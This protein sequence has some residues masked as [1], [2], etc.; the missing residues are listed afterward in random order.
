MGLTAYM[1]SSDP[2]RVST[3]TSRD[4]NKKMRKKL[5][6]PGTKLDIHVYERMYVLDCLEHIGGV[7]VPAEIKRGGGPGIWI[8]YGIGK[9]CP[10]CWRMLVAPDG[11]KEPPVDPVKPVE[12]KPV[13]LRETKKKAV[14]T[15]SG[16]MDGDGPTFNIPVVA[17]WASTHG[18]FDIYQVMDQFQV[19]RTKAY[20]L[21]KLMV[22]SRRLAVTVRRGQGQ[23]STFELIK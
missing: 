23:R 12:E 2:N 18:E 16:R 11:T 4:G 17:L 1:K 7:S 21:L 6:P 8:S 19:S 13:V 15:K 3:I 22:R 10:I 20:G 14:G 9:F 5:V